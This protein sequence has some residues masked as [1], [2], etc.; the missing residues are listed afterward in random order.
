MEFCLTA[1][2]LHEWIWGQRI[3]K[4]FNVQSDLGLPALAGGKPKIDHFLQYLSKRCPD[5]KTAQAIA[6]GSKHFGREIKTGKHDGAFDSGFN[7]GF[8]ISYLWVEG[9][10]QDRQDAVDLLDALVDFWTGF[11][12]QYLR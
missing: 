6:N 1:Y 11:F 9:D 7:R 4:D 5:L 3:K 10:N 2:H 8:D 12:E